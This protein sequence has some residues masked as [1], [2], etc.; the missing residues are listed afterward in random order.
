MAKAIDDLPFFI[1]GH[2]LIAI[3]YKFGFFLVDLN[4]NSNTLSYAD[5]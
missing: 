2:N 3:K 1:N 4:I 5:Y